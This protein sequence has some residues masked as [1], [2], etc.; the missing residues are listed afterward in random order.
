MNKLIKTNLLCLVPGL[1]FLVMCAAVSSGEEL[2]VT[3]EGVGAVTVSAASARD[4]AIEDALRR[5]VEQ[6]VGTFIDSESMV[7]NMVLLSDTVYSKSR[8]YVKNYK[9]IQELEENSLYRIKIHATVGTDGIRGDL[10]AIGLLMQ[11]KHK[12]RVMIIAVE[13]IEEKDLQVLE[14]LSVTENSMIR[15]F[16]Q[17]GFKVID[18]DTV[19]K[20]AKRD[21]L[22]SALQGDNMLAAKI[23]LQYGAEVVVI[24]KATASS[25]GYVQNDSKLQSIN[26][27]VT[28]RVIRA[29][30]AEIIAAD[31]RMSTKAHISVVKGA[32][33]AFKSAGEKLADTLIDQILS[34]WSDETTNLGSVVLV[35]SGIGS[36]SDLIEFKK[37][38]TRNVRGVKSIHQRSFTGGVAKLEIDLRGDTQTLAE[39]L[40]TQ[41]MGTVMIDVT[42]MTQNK[43]QARVKE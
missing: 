37:A 4:M 14:N 16:Q 25:S 12:P 19:K 42:D 11:R 41:K 13:T 23:G 36:F 2:E 32:H 7:E 28:A 15:M 38:L 21:Q 35:I 34:K 39:M 20:V 3:S 40:V 6:V 22:L 33:K 17:K 30:N 43:I 8:G 26:A 18:A 5:A 10:E 27:N 29:D 31:D 24:G 1:F 9:I